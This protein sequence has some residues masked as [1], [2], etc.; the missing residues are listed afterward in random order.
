M[1]GD[2]LLWLGEPL[3]SFRVFSAAWY[4]ERAS[5]IK[6]W[7]RKGPA[8]LAN[9]VAE[10]SASSLLRPRDER[11]KLA[12]GRH[13]FHQTPPFADR[14]K[15]GANDGR[16]QAPRSGRNLRGARRA[17]MSLPIGPTRDFAHH[18]ARATATPIDIN[19]EAP[20]AR[21]SA[22]SDLLRYL[23]TDCTEVLQSVGNTAQF[24]SFVKINNAPA[25]SRWSASTSFTAE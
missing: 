20:A 9:G 16:R 23:L 6:L 14:D 22:A 17:L 12:R 15:A 13:R 10:I 4:S 24:H 1:A 21:T 19:T 5:K 11:Q 18:A 2:Q 7:I 8:E 25:H 3:S